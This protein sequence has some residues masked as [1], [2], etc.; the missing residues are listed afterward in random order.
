[1]PDRWRPANGIVS[2]NALKQGRPDG[3]MLLLG[4]VSI[5]SFNPNLSPNLPYDSWRDFTWIAP[6]ADTRKDGSAW[7]PSWWGSTSPRT[8]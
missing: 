6:I 2:I 4:G 5:L 1:M 8:A 3:N 7:T